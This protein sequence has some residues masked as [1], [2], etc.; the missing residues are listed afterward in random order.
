MCVHT[1]TGKQ[2]CMIK[3]HPQALHLDLQAR[4]CSS[5][6]EVTPI[7]RNVTNIYTPVNAMNLCNL[8]HTYHSPPPHPTPPL[9]ITPGFRL[10]KFSSK[11]TLESNKHQLCRGGQFQ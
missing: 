3:I 1:H 10:G 2:T 11:V 9:N 7:Y 6:L 8:L 5:P 4:V